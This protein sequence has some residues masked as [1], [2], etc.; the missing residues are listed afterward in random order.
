MKGSSDMA[1]RQWEVWLG[2]GQ[3]NSMHY[4]P[5]IRPQVGAQRW[6][7]GIMY[8]RKGTFGIRKSCEQR[9]GHP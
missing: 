4:I 1:V 7:R 2:Y 6:T 9:P 5:S 8:R 3:L